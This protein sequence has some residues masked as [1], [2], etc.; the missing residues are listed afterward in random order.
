[1]S[2]STCVLVEMGEED[3]II[4]VAQLVAGLIGD[5]DG[6]VVR[7]WQCAILR[8]RAVGVYA[9]RGQRQRHVS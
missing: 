4:S 9:G 2:A 5:A 3:P 7:V 8:M 1:M 6:K